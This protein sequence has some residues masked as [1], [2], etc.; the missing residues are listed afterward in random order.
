MWAKLTEVKW[1][2]WGWSWFSIHV[3]PRNADLLCTETA[4][5]ARLL[6]RSMTQL[7]HLTTLCK[8]VSATKAHSI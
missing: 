2:R 1:R 7:S 3:C 6:T 4:L 5:H 8:C